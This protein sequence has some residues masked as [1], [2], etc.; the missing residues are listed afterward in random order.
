LEAEAID[1]VLDLAG[2]HRARRILTILVARPAVLEQF[3]R[4][5][6]QRFAMQQLEMRTSRA[7]IRDRLIARGMSVRTAYRVIGAAIDA[8]PRICA[9]EGGVGGTN[10]GDASADAP[11][12]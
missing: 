3:E 4:V 11:M 1:L 9:T 12:T 8:R 5:V 10:R 7:L 6:A 2:E